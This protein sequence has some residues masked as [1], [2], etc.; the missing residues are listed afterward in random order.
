M[1]MNHIL[2]LI[3]VLCR[4]WRP[5]IKKWYAKLA[6]KHNKGSFWRVIILENMV[7]KKRMFIT[8]L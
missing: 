7:N 1:W 8:D 2:V 6:G 4:Y 5:F 3:N